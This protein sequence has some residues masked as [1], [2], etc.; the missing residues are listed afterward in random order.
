MDNGEIYQDGIEGGSSQFGTAGKLI[1][2]FGSV[3]K[4]IVN[5]K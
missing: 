5:L 4:S 1:K 2:G 3:L